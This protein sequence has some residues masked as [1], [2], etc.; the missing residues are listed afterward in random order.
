MAS[1][2]ARAMV[3]KI[4]WARASGS[5]RLAPTPTIVAYSLISH[6]PRRVSSP[7]C[8]WRDLLPLHEEGVGPEHGAITHRHPIVDQGVDAD[9]GAGA[10]R[11]PVAFE[12]AVLLRVVLDLAPV[13]EDR[14]VADGG[15]C[16]LGNVGAVV[17]HPAPQPNAHQPPEHVL[18]RSAVE[19][20]EVMNRMQL[21]QTLDQ[22][23]IGMV[24]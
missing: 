2:R 8:A 13:I 19:C 9:R 5:A 22:P 24:N 3:S 6:L 16:R 14:F 1:G 17:E 11:R 21:P 20:V 18:E 4:S 10:D 15:E 12:R 23:E 7:A